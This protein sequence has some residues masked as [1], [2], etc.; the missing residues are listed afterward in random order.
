[1]TDNMG[2]LQ[3]E[4]ARANQELEKALHNLKERILALILS[5]QLNIM[6]VLPNPLF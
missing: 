2:R 1:M 4:A 5:L 6:G 3:A